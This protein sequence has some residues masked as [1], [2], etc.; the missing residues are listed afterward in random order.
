MMKKGIFALILALLVAFPFAGTAVHAEA[1]VSDEVKKGVASYIG[2]EHYDYD[3][4]SLSIE[5]SE[6]FEVSSSADKEFS[7]VTMM[8]VEFQTV[9]DNIFFEDHKQV[10]FYDADANAVLP[11]TKVLDL[12]QAKE[13]KDSH[14]EETGSHLHMGV[15]LF[16]HFLMI[17]VPAIIIYV[18][19]KGWYTTLGFKLKNNVYKTNATF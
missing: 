19:I 14:A 12:D 16:L 2:E 7:Q 3:K 15:V 8:V 4:G 10:I 5:E 18:F 13:F 1:D 6:S 11:D 17:I 9:R